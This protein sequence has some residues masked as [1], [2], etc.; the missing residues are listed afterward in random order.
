MVKV[1]KNTTL[2][3]VVTTV[4]AADVIQLCEAGRYRAA[5]RAI[6]GVTKT[7]PDG[8][9]AHGMVA[10]SRGD[11]ETA[12]DYLT[13]VAFGATELAGRGKV[14]LAVAYWF[15]GEAQEA[16]DLLRA[17]GDSFEKFMLRAI[18]ESE[19][20]YR[21]SD[22]LKLLDKAA[23]FDVRPAM[24]ARMHNQRGMVLRKM[25]E[26]DRAFQEYE[27]AIYFFEQDKSDC[28]PLVLNNLA[29]VYLDCEQFQRAHERV[30]KAISLLG[31]DL[32]HLGKAYDQKARIF[33]A[34]NNYADA[35]KCIE[36]AV[37]VLRV[38][39]RREW[40]SEALL[41]KAKI[42]KAVNESYLA[43]LEEAERVCGLIQREDLLIDVYLM[44][45]DLAQLE[46]ERSEK[47]LIQT[48]LRVFRGSARPAAKRLGITHP[49]ISKLAKKYGVKK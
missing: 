11:L 27:A 13:A 42:L 29:G 39:D 21:H 16:K 40:L 46:F 12:K 15:G 23:A 48:A 36:R 3:R 35:K 14:Q 1:T 5:E 28:V 34:E 31:D 32:P 2:E 38:S 24:Q 25:K 7:A 44:Q 22:A 6:D 47:L 4:E 30:D 18:I 8:L 17:A 33:V 41:T 9:L 19:P 45:R 49:T 26:F 10:I 37:S 43:P 20:P